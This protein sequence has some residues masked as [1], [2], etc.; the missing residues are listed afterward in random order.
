[1]TVRTEIINGF[2]LYRVEAGNISLVLVPALGGRIVSLRHLHGEREWLDGWSPENRRRLHL[3]ADP[4]R[5]ET[6]PGA[7]ID[8]CL[9]TV[10]A[11]EVDGHPLPD[12]GELWRTAPAFDPQ[13]LRCAWRLQCLPLHFE[14]CLDIEGNTLRLNYRLQNTAARPVPYQWAWHPLFT[15]ETQDRLH[16]EPTPSHCLATDGRCLLWPGAE[17]GQDLTRADVGVAQPP[18]AKVFVEVPAA[19]RAEI[20]GPGGSLRLDWP[21]ELLP[22]AGLWINRGAW[23]GL[24]HWAIEP[25]NLARDRLSEARPGDDLTTL[26]PLETRAWQLRLTLQPPPSC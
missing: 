15:L 1:M 11:C 23:N 16:F 10:L 6:G 26:R 14:R 19:A 2:E 4:S 3:P 8:E 24:H 7:G 20:R 22:W 25:T 13:T 17:P 5:Y 12:H 18:C 21:G 9:P